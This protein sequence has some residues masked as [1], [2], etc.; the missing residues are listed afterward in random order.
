MIKGGET[1]I[2]MGFDLLG[3]WMGLINQ[4][5]IQVILFDGHL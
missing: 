1:R 4:L 5:L 3:S 2:F